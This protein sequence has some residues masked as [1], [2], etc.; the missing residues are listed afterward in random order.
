MLIDE[1]HFNRWNMC[2]QLIRSQ[3]IRQ[4]RGAADNEFIE[5]VRGLTILRDRGD[6]S[7]KESTV[8]SGNNVRPDHP[9]RALTEIWVPALCYLRQK[10]ILF[11]NNHNPNYQLELS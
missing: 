11:N 2:A 8:K 9:M 10:D 5:R 6:L 3:F 7:A 4:D 1:S